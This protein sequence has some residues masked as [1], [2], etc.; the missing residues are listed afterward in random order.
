M[1]LYSSLRNVEPGSNFLVCKVLDNS[2]QYF[3][4]YLSAGQRW[5]AR[6][7][8]R[9]VRPALLV[10]LATSL[11]GYAILAWAPFPAQQPGSHS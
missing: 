5:D 6:R 8:L 2:I 3:V 10:A 1:K 11:L 7:G 4:L 9:E